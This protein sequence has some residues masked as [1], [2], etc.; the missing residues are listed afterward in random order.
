MCQNPK[1]NLGRIIAHVRASHG[2]GALVG[3][4][5]TRDSVYHTFFTR[6][7]GGGLSNSLYDFHTS[8]RPVPVVSQRGI[9][10]MPDVAAGRYTLAE[11]KLY[12]EEEEA[13][14][15]EAC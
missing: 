5:I 1:K 3:W 6:A 14:A 8:A 9:Y 4:C 2:D 13:K 11:T 15:A 7:L 10:R 12:L